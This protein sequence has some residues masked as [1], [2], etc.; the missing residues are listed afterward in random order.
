M[1]SEVQ[2]DWIYTH[3]TDYLGAV[4]GRID[5]ATEQVDIAL[6]HWLDL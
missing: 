3:A 2:V 4:I 1:P 6:R 5:A